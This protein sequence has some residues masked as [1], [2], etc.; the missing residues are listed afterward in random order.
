MRAPSPAPIE[1]SRTK[2]ARYWTIVGLF[3]G[4]IM[5]A[6]LHTVEADAEG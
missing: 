2:F 5:R 3:V 6:T 1:A 4:V